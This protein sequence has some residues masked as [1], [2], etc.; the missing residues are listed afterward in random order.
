MEVPYCQELAR[1]IARV[2]G[3]CLCYDSA[4]RAANPLLALNNPTKR[5][6]RQTGMLLPCSFVCSA[7]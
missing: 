2:L 3:P 5:W 4:G 1:H 6:E 7:A